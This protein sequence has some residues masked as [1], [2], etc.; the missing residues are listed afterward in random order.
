MINNPIF[1]GGTGRSGT[2]MLTKIL[3]QD[4]DI[5]YFGESRFLVDKGGVYDILK[6]KCNKDIFQNRMMHS[7]R[8]RIIGSLKTQGY[9]SRIY[10][11]QNIYNIFKKCFVL[12]DID[13]SELINFVRFI[14]ELGLN[15]F[16]KNI[17]L[18]KTPHTNIMVDFLYK[19]FPDM[20]Y[21]HIIRDPRDIYCSMLCQKWGPKNKEDFIKY[22][23]DNMI[24]SWNSHIDIPDE[25]YMYLRL[26]EIVE[27]PNLSMMR[28]LNFTK[29]IHKLKILKRYIFYISEKKAHIDRWRNELSQE[30][31]KD[32]MKRCNN[33]YNR[34]I[35]R[36]QRISNIK[37]PRRPK[38][39]RFV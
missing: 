27:N 29:L 17:L 28:I 11:K 13:E 23:N 25:N 16:K 3:S 5:L 30:D 21:I 9:K 33:S 18:E 22:Y 31:S 10:T 39:I 20:R 37:V 14:Y 32:I 7:L 26:E 2:S 4:R 36:K 6:K 38:L 12:N 24:T 1:I 19:V 15:E 35:D 34:W 8:T